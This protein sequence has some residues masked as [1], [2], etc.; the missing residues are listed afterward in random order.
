MLSIIGKEEIKRKKSKGGRERRNRQ[1]ET[2]RA[3]ERQ[4]ERARERIRKRKRE[5]VADRVNKHGQT[6]LG[7]ERRN[8]QIKKVI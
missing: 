4:R 5:R 1:G 2:E 7:I 6:G 8:E 3:R